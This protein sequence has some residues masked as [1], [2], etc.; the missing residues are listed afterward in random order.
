[1]EVINLGDQC[2]HYEDMVLQEGKKANKFGKLYYLKDRI[3][4]VQRN[5]VTDYN[6]WS[7]D[8]GE[9]HLRLPLSDD[10]RKELDSICKVAVSKMPGLD[11]KVY[12]NDNIFIKF[13]KDCSSHIELNGELQFTIQI[14]GC[15]TQNATGK[16]F[17]QM[18][19]MEHQSTKFSLLNNNKNAGVG[20]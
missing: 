17:L 12:E 2:G 6:I 13:G 7:S 10:L 3:F 16:T 5:A 11:F 18:D 14:Y 20:A 15:F 9:K 19:I 8:K 4:L 1:M